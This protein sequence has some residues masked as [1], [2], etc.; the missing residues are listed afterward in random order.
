MANGRCR[1][2]GGKSTGPRTPEG[3]ERSR[4]ANFKHGY[5]SAESIAERRLIRQLLHDSR[6]T[7]EQVERLGLSEALCEILRALC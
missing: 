6:E 7:I 2:H 5:Y 3:L 4:K 1:M